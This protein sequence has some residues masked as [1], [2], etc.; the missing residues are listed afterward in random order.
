MRYRVQIS[1]DGT[2]YCG[3]QNQPNGISIQQ[4]LENRLG[5]KLQKE[6]SI[7]GCCRTD[8]GVHAL[9]SYFHFDF[10]GEL[11][12]DFIHALNYFLPFDISVNEI[13]E[14]NADFHARFDA[15]ARA[16]VYKIHSIK[17]PF[18]HNKS[19]YF[20]Q[21][22]NIDPSVLEEA[23]MIIREGT[24]F[25]PFC[26]TTSDAKTMYCQIMEAC[27]LFDRDHDSYE[28]HISANRFL[29]GMVRLIAG[30][31]LQVGLGKM[32]MVELRE[33][34][35]N[36]QPLSKPWAVPAEGLYLKSILYP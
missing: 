15:T 7:T 36:Q 22:K 16:Y 33:A 34:L 18:K 17:N 25:G 13:V 3:W 11:P 19:F 12:N 21:I 1:Y 31:S 6:I 27:W 23:A 5:I 2:S 32:N 29:R 8:S 9:Q 4:I 26:K 24:E 35:V 10:D 14:V 28:F 20:P 30:A